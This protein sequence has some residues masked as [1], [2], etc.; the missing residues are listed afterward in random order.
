MSDCRLDTGDYD[1]RN[2]LRVSLPFPPEMVKLEELSLD[3]HH[4]HPS[5]CIPHSPSHQ[6]VPVKALLSQGRIPLRA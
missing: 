5:E 1:R 3:P 2:A 4:H 6:P